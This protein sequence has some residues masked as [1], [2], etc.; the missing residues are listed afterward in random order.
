MFAEASANSSNDFYNFIA[1]DSANANS[2]LLKEVI[3]E[4]ERQSNLEKV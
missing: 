1:E 2:N 4:L 3:D